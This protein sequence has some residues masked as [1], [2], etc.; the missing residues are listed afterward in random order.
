MRIW[1]VADSYAPVVG[2]IEVHVASL[3]AHQDARGHRVRVVTL[4]PDPAAAPDGSSGV[5]DSSGAVDSSG[6]AVTRLRAPGTGLSL[7]QLAGLTD[8]LRRRLRAERP[9]VVHVHAS[10]LSPLAA[11]ALRAA[12]EER[13]PAVAT[14]HSMWAGMGPLPWAV[15]HAVSPQRTDT[16]WS[17]VSRVAADAVAPVVAPRPVAVLPNAVEP[18]RWAGLGRPS[19]AGA[20]VHVVAVMRLTRVKRAVPLAAVLRA[21]RR[22]LPEDVPLRATVAGGG[23]QRAAL[24]RYLR[25]HGMD[26]VDLPGPVDRAG[27]RDLLATADVFVAPAYRE[28]FGIAALEARAAGVPLVA[29]RSSG[30]TEFV[31][32][33][34]EGLLADDDAGM[35]AAIARL[36]GDRALRAAVR[37]HDRTV[38]VLHDWDRAVAG[39]DALYVRAAALVGAAP[40]ALPVGTPGADGAGR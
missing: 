40:L 19:P 20:P 21:A 15:R 5:T 25:R 33:G 17:A 13:V 18:D 34:A 10:V 11:A 27:V 8:D 32:D 26:W 30:V 35:A 16:V 2:G 22:A 1:H 39:A 9:D 3:A 4:A 23:P 31:T 38:P 24:E 12:H 7:H 37:E 6:V 14:V 29:P 28:S 36:A